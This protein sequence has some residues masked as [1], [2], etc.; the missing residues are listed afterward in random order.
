MFGSAPPLIKAATTS[1]CPAIAAKFSGVRCHCGPKMF[2]SAP[3][4]IRATTTSTCPSYAAKCSG[5]QPLSPQPAFGSASAFGFA[6][7]SIR[8][9]TNSERPSCA[10]HCSGTQPSSLWAFG[11]APAS[12]QIMTDFSVADA[13]YVS[14][15]Q[16]AQLDACA[17]TFGLAKAIAPANA[18]RSIPAA[19]LLNKGKKTYLP[20]SLCRDA[21][22][23]RRS[24]PIL[25]GM[26]TEELQ[27][28]LFCISSEIL[29]FRHQLLR[30]PTTERRMAHPSYGLATQFSKPAL[31]LLFLRQRRILRK[32]CKMR[33]AMSVTFAQI[34]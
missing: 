22:Q 28:I 27:N 10:A 33:Q 34:A 24:M 23:T 17:L 2:G 11:S 18:A 12:K 29:R 1:E 15:P 25:V 4:S 8:G 9:A 5:A 7:A 19:F 6:P 31:P 20:S 21:T 14:V 16:S 26:L 30:R 3:A 13:K 32:S